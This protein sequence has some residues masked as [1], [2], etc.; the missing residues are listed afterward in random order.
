MGGGGSGFG[1]F[2]ATLHLASHQTEANKE[3]VNRQYELI[4]REKPDRIVY[5]GKAVYPFLWE[6]K[7]KNKTI[8]ISRL[9]YIHYVKGHTHVAFN[10]NYGTFFNRHTFSL[11]HFGMVTTIMIS[12]KWLKLPCKINKSAIREILK[13]GKAIYTVSPSLFS[14]PV[15]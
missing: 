1:K 9:P 13:H 3:L 8:P 6:L 11:V 7:N 15:Y 10:S 5:N 12:K 2:L 14:R 4:E